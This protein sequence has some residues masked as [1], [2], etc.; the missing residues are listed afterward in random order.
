MTQN[1][2]P[3]AQ[4]IMSL[5][6]GTSSSRAVIYDLQG[7]VIASGQQTFDMSFPEDGWVEQNPEVLWQTTLDSARAALAQAQSQAGIEVHQLA[8]I[9]ITNQRETTLVWDRETGECIYPAIVWQ[10]RRTAEFCEAF[11]QREIGGLPAQAFVANTT[12]LVIDPYF[13]GTKLAWILDQVPGAR[14]RAEKG[15]LCFGTVDSFLVWKLSCGA[16]HITDASNAS[17]TALFDIHRQT[18]SPELLDA[19]DIPAS[20]L[21]NVTD[22]AGALAQVDPKWFGASVPITGIAGDQQ[23]ALVGQACFEPGMSKSTYGTGCFLMTN[24]GST[25]VRSEHQ[26]LTTVAYRLESETV[27][28]LEGSI[29]VAGVAMKWLRDKLGLIKDVSETQT[30]YE[31]TGGDSGGVYVVPAFTGL[32]A[33]YWRPDARGTIS[34]LT[35]DSSRAQ[36][37]TAFLQGVVFQTQELLAA[38]ASDGAP[39]ERL[40]VDGGMVVNDALCQCLADILQ[41]DVERPANVETTALGAALLAGLGAGLFESLPAAAQQWRLERRFEPV[42]DVSLRDQL[43][44]G[45]ERAVQRAMD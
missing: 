23:A 22:N 29:F 39:I 38:M 21:P 13:S 5:D 2:N 43:L 11:K 34:G 45:Y 27:Y 14:D 9:G 36:L 1:N 44:A 35:L 17:R 7:E 26:L 30:A 3:N 20:I 41:V 18:F 24:T 12:G 28:A 8:A 15:E 42:M 10:D 6:Q 32:G 40:R 33:P 16:A 31:A 25:P 37:I 4:Y 19:L